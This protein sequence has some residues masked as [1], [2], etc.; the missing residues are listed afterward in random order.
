MSTL[1]PKYA[2]P[3]VA[4]DSGFGEAKKKKRQKSTGTK[5]RVGRVE[6]ALAREDGMLP[7]VD[8]R[9]ILFLE[10]FHGGLLLHWITSCNYVF[11]PPFYTGLQM[12]KPR[13]RRRTR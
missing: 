3:G 13:E 9:R 7:R 4:D 12:M 6:D 1:L 5:V 2:N 8:I 10:S 11:I